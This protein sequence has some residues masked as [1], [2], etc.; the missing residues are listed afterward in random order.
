MIK[1]AGNTVRAIVIFISILFFSC[2]TVAKKI[3]VV[4]PPGYDM[5]SPV[6][7]PL[8]V[9][10]D[11]ISGLDFY[12]KDTS[13]FAINDE[14]GIL[15]KIYIRNDIK[16]ETWKF[17]GSGDYEDIHRVD[18]SFYVMRSDGTIFRLGF[19]TPETPQVE[20]YKI[21]LKGNNEFE[22]LYYDSILKKL[23]LICKDCKEDNK[24][25]VSAF[26]FDPETNTFSDDPVFTI[27]G[28]KVVKQAEVDKDKF[29]P[30]AAAIN[31]VTNELF[32]ISAINKTLVIADRDG[33]VKEVIDLDKKLF[34][35]P[36]GITFTPDGTML[37]SNEGAGNGS[38][39]ILIFKYKK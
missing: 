16:I 5:A 19:S 12:N 7:I 36:E 38:G 25:T 18:S 11:E 35:Q 32:M 22:S 28:K 30:S 13:V 34:K 2:Q 14:Q 27:K 1:Y 21:S 29:K 17:A 39:E 33:S 37:I 9:D 3:N 8:G 23:I 15:F 10:L 31:P 4:S 6:I 26:A 24:K 20:T